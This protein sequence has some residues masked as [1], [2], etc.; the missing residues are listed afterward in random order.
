MAYAD[1]SGGATTIKMVKYPDALQSYTIAAGNVPAFSRDGRE[2]YFVDGD[3]LRA[4]SLENESDSLRIVGA[5]RE[6]FRGRYSFQVAG[7]AWDVHPDGRFL[8]LR[9]EEDNNASST[10]ERQRIHIVV[11]WIEEVRRRL[12][13]E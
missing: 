9:D 12:A 1:T 7:R 13:A 3:G 11:N 6:V 10:P 5:P 4:Q 8:V 2:L